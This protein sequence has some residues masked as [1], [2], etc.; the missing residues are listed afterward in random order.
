MPRYSQQL[1]Y[2]G[3]RPQEVVKF[4]HITGF[5]G[6]SEK[7]LLC[8]VKEAA[9]RTSPPTVATIALLAVSQF[10]NTFKCQAVFVQCAREL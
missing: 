6:R 2:R 5:G 9:Q 1:L 3:V 4:I 8:T 7:L 10:H